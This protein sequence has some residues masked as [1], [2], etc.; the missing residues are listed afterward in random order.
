MVTAPEVV[1]ILIG[2]ELGGTIETA[3]V[4][5]FAVPNDLLAQSNG[6]NSS[7]FSFGA[8]QLDIGNNSTA[9]DAY[10]EILSAA[11]NQGAIT[12]AEHDRFIRYNGVKRPDL[13]ADLAP[14]YRADR[15]ALNAKVFSQVSIR[16]IIDKHV[17]AYVS[18]S[19][20]PSVNNFL[21]AVV[22]KWGEDCV[23]ATGHADYHTAVAAM[24]SI[25]NRTGGL[26]QSTAHFLDTQPRSLQEVKDRYNSIGSIRGHWHLVEQGAKLFRAMG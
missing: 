24:T 5:S 18:A 6:G 10:R 13:V 8:V 20:L 25:S 26:N 2:S 4:L 7:G 15:S 17:E 9:Q 12:D 11:R 1:R 21:A 22:G 16:A 23:F 3:Y 14:H 19:L